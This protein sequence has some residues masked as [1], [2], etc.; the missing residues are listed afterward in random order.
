MTALSEGKAR[1]DFRRPEN[2]EF[3]LAAWRY[4]ANLGQRGTWRTSYEWAK[5]VLSLDPEGDPYCIAINLDQLALQGGQ[6]EHFLNLCKCPPLDQF[7]NRPNLRISNALAKHRLKD[8]RGSRLQ[9][10]EAM[11]VYP[12]IFTRLFQELNLEHIPKSIWGKKPRTNREKFECEVYVHNAKDLWNTP[13]AISLLV[14]VAESVEPSLMAPLLDHDITLDEGRHI[15]LSGTPSLIDLLP[16]TFTTMHTTSSDPLPPPD[17]LF[18]YVSAT[19]IGVSQAQESSDEQQDPIAVPAAVDEGDVNEDL[20][21][22]MTGLQNFFSRFLPQY[23][24][25]SDNR[26]VQRAAA[27]SGESEDAVRQRGNRFLQLARRVMGMGL[28]SERTPQATAQQA[29]EQPDASSTEPMAVREQ[30]SDDE[31]SEL[32][33]V[34]PNSDNSPHQPGT[35]AE[36]LPTPQEEPYDDERNQRWLAGRGMI[37]LRDFTARY[38]TEEEAWGNNTDEGVAL[39]SEYASRVRRLRQQR[40]RDFIVNYPLRQGT[41]VEVRDLV[42]RYIERQ[43]P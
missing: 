9:L 32:P 6:A 22:E 39:V 38:G 35:S 11:A 24:S 27:D 8:A 2:R 29:S 31:H 1:L 26:A 3:W 7:L 18:S 40:T 14:E 16:R 36:A 21:Q 13:E 19:G 25:I 20:L 43:R 28:G 33:N 4:V 10:Q 12:Y 23:D 5:L 30:D 17:N 37:R 34:A 42:Q 41:S 15:L